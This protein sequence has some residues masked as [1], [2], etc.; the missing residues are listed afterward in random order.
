MFLKMYDPAASKEKIKIMCT[1]LNEL[2]ATL[3]HRYTAAITDGMNPANCD[4]TVTS[5]QEFEV[6]IR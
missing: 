4:W 6:I 1:V 3:K 2:I 5:R